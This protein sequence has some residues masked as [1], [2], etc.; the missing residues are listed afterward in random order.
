[1]TD[2]RRKSENSDRFYFW[3]A[4]KSLLMLTAARKL[5]YLLHR[6]KAMPNLDSVLKSRNII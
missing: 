4:P 1:M 6:R 3:G 2:T 5:R